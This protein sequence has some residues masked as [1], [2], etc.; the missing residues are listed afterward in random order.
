[1]SEYF[2]VAHHTDRGRMEGYVIIDQSE[3]KL[4]YLA[5][6]REIAKDNYLNVSSDFTIESI[7]KL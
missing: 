1:M 5:I 3:L 4:I 2:Y 6:R 7:T